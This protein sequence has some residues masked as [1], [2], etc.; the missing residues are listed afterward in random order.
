MY[1]SRRVGPFDPLTFW[2]INWASSLERVSSTLERAISFLADPN[3][4]PPL[5][6]RINRKD[7]KQFQ[8]HIASASQSVDICGVLD[9]TVVALRT[10]DMMRS[11]RSVESDLVSV[12]PTDIEEE[13][14]AGEN[15]E[16][17][18]TQDSSV[19]GR[20]RS[21]TITQA[22]V[23]MSMHPFHPSR[24]SSL[25]PSS[26]SP[27]SQSQSQNQSQAQIQNHRARQ[28]LQ[29]LR[30]AQ[31]SELENDLAR[32]RFFIWRIIDPLA[33]VE[34]QCIVDEVLPSIS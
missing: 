12:Q 10:I 33:K 26:S 32:V 14:E 19:G 28:A 24:T 20:G 21:R 5:P 29:R 17:I 7:A 11:A 27:P 34:L 25:F 9:K 18:S 3:A 30:A 4:K 1:R 23:S 16:S 8:D 2:M 13:E 15:E 22:T 31:T 6:K